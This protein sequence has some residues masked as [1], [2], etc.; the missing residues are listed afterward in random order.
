MK[1]PKIKD[2]WN[3]LVSG[4]RESLKEYSEAQDKY[5]DYL[6]NKSKVEF[7]INGSELNSILDK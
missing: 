3:G 2:Y 6:E 1:R 7:K 4:M 5:I